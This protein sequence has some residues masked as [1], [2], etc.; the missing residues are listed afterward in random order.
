MFNT[1]ARVSEI[2]ALQTTDLQMASAPSVVLRGKGRKERICP[3]WPETA[4]LLE[5]MLE[6]RGLKPSESVPL[7]LNHRGTPLTRFGVRLILSKYIRKS[8]PSRADAKEQTST[9]PQ[10]A[11]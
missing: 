5:K 6:E 9:S 3:V 8:S 7:F 1:G 2:V 11:P 4:Q 10:S